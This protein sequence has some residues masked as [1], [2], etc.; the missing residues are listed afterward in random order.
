M[1][2]TDAQEEIVLLL[3]PLYEKLGLILDEDLAKQFIN[4]T[5]NAASDQVEDEHPWTSEGNPFVGDG[6]VWSCDKEPD[7]DPLM[8]ELIKEL[9]NKGYITAGCCQGRTLIGD[10]HCRHAFIV[11]THK[12]SASIRM[13]A[14]DYGLYPADRADNSLTSPVFRDTTDEEAIELNAKFHNAI[15]EIFLEDNK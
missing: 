10:S 9:N 3:K 6:V 13:M 1:N 14:E 11:F 4:A 15:R 5:I 8:I 2:H 7:I 12:I